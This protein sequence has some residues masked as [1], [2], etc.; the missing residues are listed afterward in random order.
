MHKRRVK[1]TYI[2]PEESSNAIWMADFLSSSA[3]APFFQKLVLEA[4]KFSGCPETDTENSNQEWAEGAWLFCIDLD[5]GREDSGSFRVERGC[6]GSFPTT[7][8]SHWFRN[9]CRDGNNM[10]DIYIETGCEVL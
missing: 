7:D 3:S 9:V 4:Y 1:H 8:Y 6:H 2:V 10:S 5:A